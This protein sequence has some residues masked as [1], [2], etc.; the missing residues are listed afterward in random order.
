MNP[1]PPNIAETL[2]AW[3]K[4]AIDRFHQIREIVFV[5]ATRDEVGPLVE[6]LKWGQPS[7]LP[8]KPRVGTTLRCNW[9]QARPDHL[10][11]FVNCQTDL[12]ETVKTIYPKD[13]DYDGKRALHMDLRVPLPM[14]AIEHCAALTLRY[15]RKTA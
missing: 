4:L 15:H 13:F 12:L 10:S 5:V 9:T 7:W 8:A 2:A 3:P 14:D 1:L 11:L 6:T